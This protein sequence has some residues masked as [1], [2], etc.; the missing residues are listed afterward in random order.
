MLAEL[1]KGPSRAAGQEQEARKYWPSWTSPSPGALK[2]A[3]PIAVAADKARHGNRA[4]AS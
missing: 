1:E 2:T 3:E 4:R